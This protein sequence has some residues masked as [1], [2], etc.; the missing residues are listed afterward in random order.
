MLC[1]L[2]DHDAATAEAERAVRC[3]ATSASYTVLTEVRLRAGDRPGADRDDPDLLRLRGQIAIE[4]GDRDAGL[5]WL[6]RALFQG[7]AGPAYSWKA[8]ALMGL[9]RYEP[10]VEAW[11]AALSDDPEHPEAF[12][13]RARCLRLLGLWEN[14]LADLEQAAERAPDGSS[15]LARVMFEYLAILPARSDRLPR[16]AGL[17]RRLLAGPPSDQ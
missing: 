12:L 15:L 8:R 2:N 5:R 3:S 6:D 16:V 10:A 11:S 13:G 17:A 9:G 7:A 14:A 1:A 4:A